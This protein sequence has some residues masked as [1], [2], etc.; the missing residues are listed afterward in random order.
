[1][2]KLWSASKSEIANSNLAN[3]EVISHKNTTK[4]SKEIIK[5]F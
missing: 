4:S 2:R 3:Y 1:M 5:I